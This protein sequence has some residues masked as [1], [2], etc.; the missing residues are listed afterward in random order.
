MTG[1]Q[2][3]RSIRENNI[4]KISHDDIRNVLSI[5]LNRTLDY[6]E[7]YLSEQDLFKTCS[8]SK[9]DYKEIMN[10]CNSSFDTQPIYIYASDLTITGRATVQGSLFSAECSFNVYEYKNSNNYIE[11]DG[12]IELDCH[13]MGPL[14]FQLSL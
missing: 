12:R 2:L 8:I 3:R 6:I 13:S 9:S 10:E 1:R 14:G 7:N 4:P 11:F 5:D